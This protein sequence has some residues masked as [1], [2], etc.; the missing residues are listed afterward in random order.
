M[1][2]SCEAMVKTIRWNVVLFICKISRKQIPQN[3][4][5]ITLY[6]IFSFIFD[7]E[8]VIL[9]CVARLCLSNVFSNDVIYT[10]SYTFV[11]NPSR[12]V[13]VKILW[14][15]LLIIIQKPLAELE[16]VS[17]IHL[18]QF[19]EVGKVRMMLASWH[20]SGK[21]ISSL[22]FSTFSLKVLILLTIAY[23]FFM[24]NLMSI[25]TNL[26]QILFVTIE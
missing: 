23:S 14:L 2:V 3:I 20:C 26:G 25:H 16:E 19:H 4:I 24:N 5:W 18:L 12:N 21:L 8:A 17:F 22:R 1:K 6:N 10:L 11:F 15:L 9:S 13:F 7:Q